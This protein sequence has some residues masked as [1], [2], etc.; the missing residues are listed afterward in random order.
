MANIYRI[1]LQGDDLL[2]WH[3]AIFY[4]EDLAIKY[5]KSVRTK[6]PNNMV[7]SERL[8]DD[9]GKILSQKI[10]GKTNGVSFAEVKA[11]RQEYINLIRYDVEFKDTRVVAENISPEEANQIII[12]EIGQPGYGT[13]Y[14]YTVEHGNFVKHVPAFPEF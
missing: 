8:D 7:V 2:G 13:E 12:S 6:H 9:T 3:T 5:F 1:Y 14:I 10:F 4:D 11:C